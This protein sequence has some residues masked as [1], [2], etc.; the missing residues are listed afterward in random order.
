VIRALALFGA[1][2][3]LAL[4]CNPGL[5]GTGVASQRAGEAYPG[6]R[7]DIRGVVEGGPNSCARLAVD[8]IPHFVIWPPGTAT[9]ELV[10]P[11]GDRVR[12]GDTITGR[13]ALTSREP[14]EGPTGATTFWRHM[15]RACD[16]ED[17]EILV[18]DSAALAR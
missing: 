14:L 12:E 8:G 17:E 7:R 1:G 10:L 3:V 11:S 18:L 15:F 2:A 16:V 6:E 9:W 5:A 13:G 4:G